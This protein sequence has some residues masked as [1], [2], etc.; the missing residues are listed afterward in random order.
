MGLPS[1]YFRFFTQ[2]AKN[3]HKAWFD[4]HRSEYE[5]DVRAPFISLVGDLISEIHRVDPAIAMQ[6]KDTMYRINRDV[7][8]SK[9]KAPYKLQMGANISRHGKKAMGKPGL[10]FEVNAKGGLI[11]VGC[12]MPNKEE[13]TMYRDLIMH[14]AADLHSALQHKQFIQLFGVL[15]GERNKVLPEEFRAAAAQEPLLFNK[16]FFAWTQVPKSVFTGADAAQQMLAYWNAA[17]PLNDFFDRVW[18]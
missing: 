3:N 2:L 9:D 13:L 12:Y 7:R 5:H 14:E 6:P 16:Q 18:E 8:F 1:G 11:A 10:Y 17:K 4:E 15:Q